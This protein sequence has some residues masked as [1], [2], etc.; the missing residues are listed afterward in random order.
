[1]K[2][3]T[4]GRYRLICFT[5]RGYET[6]KQIADGLM[7]DAEG[8]CEALN[9][10]RLKEWTRDNFEKGNVLV[11]VGAAGI[12]VRAI[13]GF[14]K[15]KTKDPAVIVVDEKGSYVI[16]ILSGHIGGA[17]REAKEIALS[18]GAEAVITTATDIN[19]EFAVDVFATENNL[20]I[21]D[22]KR[23]KEFSAGLLKDG[24]SSFFAE[25]ELMDTGVLSEI[26]DNIKARSRDDSSL[27]ISY[28][29]YDG[30]GLFLIPRCI[31]VG[32]GCR[33]GKSFEELSA[34]L[35]KCLKECGIDKR[36]VAAIA[37]ADIK[38]DEPGLKELAADLGAEFVT[39][40]I[41]RLK[42]LDGEFTSS[43]FVSSVTG[44]DNVC[45]RA[46][47]AYGAE[48]FLS[49]KI[50]KDGMTFAAGLFIDKS[51]E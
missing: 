19:N 12:A 23:A 34:F 11:F 24:K 18:L 16:P 29:P 41:E 8:S 6:M 1:M 2:Q 35:D 49:K 27:V 15:D 33:R 14:I 22:M 10:P 51:K 38:K 30:D 26:P 20:L 25:K 3:I 47:C 39:F 4:I 46:V 21:T 37:S 28:R 32:M 45:E 48:H 50:A 36:A 7:N 17:N 13:A 5:D 31:V 42:A 9:V 44:V 40:G 43:E